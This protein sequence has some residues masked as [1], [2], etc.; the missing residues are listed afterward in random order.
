MKRK[1]IGGI[2]AVPRW[3]DAHKNNALVA[4]GWSVIYL[5][6]EDVEAKRDVTM[7]HLKDLLQPRFL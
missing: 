5:T 4:L 2:P 7:S 1:A 3:W 6:W